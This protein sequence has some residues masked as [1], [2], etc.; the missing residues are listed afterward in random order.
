MS[1]TQYWS[2]IGK[3]AAGVASNTTSRYMEILYIYECMVKNLLLKSIY[4]WDEYLHSSCMA[5]V[6][7][8][9]S[10]D[11]MAVFSGDDMQ[12]IHMLLG[13]PNDQLLPG[14]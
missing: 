14:Q 7:V 3:K 12:L 1:T 2:P 13:W 10:T 9:L 6:C 8:R 4:Y 11:P 5:D